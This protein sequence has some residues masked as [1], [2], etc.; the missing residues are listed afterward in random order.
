MESVLA[1]VCGAF[2]VTLFAVNQRVVPPKRPFAVVPS[3]LIGDPYGRAQLPA[4]LARLCPDVVL[5]HDDASFYAIHRPALDEHR[6]RRPAAVVVYCPVDWPTL[7]PAALRALA[8]VDRLVLYSESSRRRVAAAFATLDVPAP[9]TAVIGHGVDATRFRPLVDGDPAASRALARRRLRW[10]GADA[11]FV[12]LNANRNSARKRLDITLAGFAELART[13]ADVRLCLHA[14][15]RGGCDVVD[16][17]RR[18]GIADRLLGVAD[19]IG[20]PKV[21]DDELNLIYNAC[22]VGL[23]TA[24][25]EGWG[26]VAFEHAAA[27]RPQ[28]LPEHRRELWSRRALLV[29]AADGHVAA[30]GVAGAL[31]LL[32]DHRR[33]RD[34]L[35]AAGRAFATSPR[36]SWDALGRRWEQLLQDAR[37]S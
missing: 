18:L 36:F 17:A 7:P 15:A 5:L 25:A 10:T 34:R 23:N 19:G 30:A 14:A 22:D 33:L 3:T 31:T 26:L 1:R 16:L 37:T 28:V 32:R 9:P 13:R 11:D 35:A 6:R 12:V 24:D 29:P 8:N 20:H 2:D 4:L 21:R 27:G